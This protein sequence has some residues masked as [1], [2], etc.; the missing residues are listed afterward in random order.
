MNKFLKSTTAFILLVAFLVSTMVCCCVTRLA[1]AAMVQIKAKSSCCPVKTGGTEHKTKDCDNTC[2]KKNLRAESLPVFNLVSPTT[3]VLKFF[4]L[5]FISFIPLVRLSTKLV[6][7][8]SPPK[9]FLNPP[10]YLK[11]HSLRI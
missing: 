8:H 7:F 1:Q 11:I 9:A 2:P 5:D 6:S 4:H 10:L 3:Y